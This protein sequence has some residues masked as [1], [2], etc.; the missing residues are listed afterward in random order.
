MIFDE[1][2]TQILFSADQIQVGIS[3]LA[4]KLNMQYQQ[5]NVVVISILKGSL[6][7]FADMIRLLK[8][9]FVCEFI[10]VSSYH[11]DRKSSGCIDLELDVTLSLTNKHVIVFEDIA[12]TG[13]TLQ[14]LKNHLLEK[15]PA[16]LRVCALLQRAAR[17]SILQ[18]V[19]DDVVFH[20]GDEFVI[21]YGLDDKGF[22]RGLPYLAALKNL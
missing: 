3:E 7:F 15:K 5:Q 2:N 8:F 4:Q 10:K 14:F 17:Q 22:G 20:I 21:G 18:T 11:N 16:S 1:K 13:L 9:P 12:D 19:I 6:V